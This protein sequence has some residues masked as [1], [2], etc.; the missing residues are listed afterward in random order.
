M[1]TDAIQKYVIVMGMQIKSL[2][3]LKICVFAVHAKIVR[4]IVLAL[5]IVANSCSADHAWIIGILV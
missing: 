5:I 4:V 2:V 1:V 3:K